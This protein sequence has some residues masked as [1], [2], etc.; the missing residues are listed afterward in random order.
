MLERIF[1]TQPTKKKV[2]KKTVKKAKKRD[3]LEWHTDEELTGRVRVIISELGFTHIPQERVFCFRTHGSAARAY[4]RTWA[5][6][7][8]FQR[9]LDIQAAYV[10]EV[11]SKY[12]DKLP[13]EE[14]TKVIIHE[15]LHIPKNFSGS[16]LPH[17]N[18][19]RGY[20]RE[21]DRFYDLLKEKK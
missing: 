1:K 17:R 12:Y 11:I 13:Y 18:G 10:I 6:P 14:Q 15:L 9:V 7:K 16:L 3:T 8:I 5:F 21:V 4:A 2:V 19:H 20:Q